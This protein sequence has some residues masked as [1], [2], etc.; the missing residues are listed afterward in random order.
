MKGNR[1]TEMGV[2]GF[3]QATKIFLWVTAGT[4]Q[5]SDSISP[6]LPGPESIY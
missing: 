3:L 6:W 1:F 2:I 5:G 4:R